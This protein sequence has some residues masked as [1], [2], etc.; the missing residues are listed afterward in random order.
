MVKVLST[1]IDTHKSSI[2][3]RDYTLYNQSRCRGKYR[4]ILILNPFLNEK[5]YILFLAFASGVNLFRTDRFAC[6]LCYLFKTGQRSQGCNLSPGFI[7]K[8]TVTKWLLRS[9]QGV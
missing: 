9:L 4:T 7:L 1:I 3:I 5:L 8:K 2:N 6:Y